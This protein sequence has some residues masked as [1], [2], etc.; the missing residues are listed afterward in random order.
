MAEENAV[1][2]EETA[3][4]NEVVVLS[5]RGLEVYVDT[6]MEIHVRIPKC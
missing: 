1:V 5:V 6:N 2:G 3:L 4:E